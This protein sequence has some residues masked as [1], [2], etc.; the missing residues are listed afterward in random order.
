[1]NRHFPEQN[2]PLL[3]GRPSITSH[4]LVYCFSGLCI[5]S[6]WSAHCLSGLSI[7]FLLFVLYPTG[8]CMIRTVTPELRKHPRTARATCSLRLGRIRLGR[9]GLGVGV[10]PAE[11]RNTEM[12]R[13]RPIAI[14]FSGLRI[15]SHRAVHC[16]SGLCISFLLRVFYR[17]SSFITCC[18]LRV[19]S[20]IS[21]I[22]QY[23]L[24]EEA[25]VRCTQGAGKDHFQSSL[26]NSSTHHRTPRRRPNQ[27]P[28]RTRGATP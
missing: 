12:L 25:G 2:L 19:T 18:V 9:I 1:M 24:Y 28:R 27:S 14:C 7:A 4:R 22:T 13:T 10:P 5:V 15:V 16:L 6:R 3:A 21:C 20:Y 8:L 26:H 23:V 17:S 11:T